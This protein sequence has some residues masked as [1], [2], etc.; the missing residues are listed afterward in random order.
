MDSTAIANLVFHLSIVLAAGLA[1]GVVSKRLGVSMLVGYLVVGILIGPGCTGLVRADQRDLETLAQAGA[2]LLLFAIGIEFTL[3][4]LARLSRY[5]FLGGGVQMVLVAV[6]AALVGVAV[7]MRP[8]EAVLIGAAAALSSTVLVFKALEEWGQAGSRH[9]RRAIGILLF[10]DVA[11]VPLMLLVPLLAGVGRRPDAADWSML[12]ARS[13]LFVAAVAALRAVVARWALPLLARMRSVELLVLFTVLVLIGG[14]FGSYVIGLP[15]ALGALSAGIVL[16]GNRLTRQLDALMLPYRETFAA[17]FFVSLGTLMRFDVLAAAPLAVLAALAGV[18]VL[19][20]AAAAVAL[21]VVGLPWAQAAGMGLGLA[22]LGEL[23]FVL[24]AVGTTG[25]PPVID[26][27]TY[28][29]M[30]FVALGTLVATPLLLR[31]GL[32]WAEGPPD[33]KAEI[34]PLSGQPIERAIVVGAGPI[35][36]R[37]AAHL[38]TLGWDVCLIDL[39]PVN[40][41]PFTQQGFR[42]VAGDAA[43]PQILRHAQ[44]NHTRLAVVTVPNDSVAGDVVTAIRGQNPQCTT[45]VRCRFQ[46]SVPAIRRAGAD[47]VLSEESEI[48]VALL[49]L[50]ERTH[51]PPDEGGQ[52]AARE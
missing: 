4:E 52:P 5:F 35:G 17:I 24:L 27:V 41:H 39:S 45:L 9:G 3:E 48:A 29:R 30:L 19:K 38:E 47:V 31:I 32:R 28:N 36:G 51:S 12:V 18:L 2:L 21:R 43:D 46:G 10:Q 23:S 40:L 7:G 13:I 26:A 22:Q 25:D 37:V 15:P 11:L 50:L 16:S 44:A 33:E 34:A 14:C 1:A 20:T 6:P 8:G 49:R 42:T